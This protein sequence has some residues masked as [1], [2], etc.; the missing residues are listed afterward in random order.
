MPLNSADIVFDHRI[1][2]YSYVIVVIFSFPFQKS[3]REQ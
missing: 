3:A 1:A 2:A